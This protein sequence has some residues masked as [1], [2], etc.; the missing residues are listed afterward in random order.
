[1]RDTV[2]EHRA[3]LLELAARPRRRRPVRP[4]GRGHPFRSARDLLRG[5]RRMG[6]AGRP[7]A[8][9]AAGHS[10]GELAALAAGGA[11]DEHDGLR[12]AVERGAIMQRAAEAGGGRDAG[13]DGRAR[14]GPRPGRRIRP[15]D[16]RTTTRPS[17][18]SSPVPQTGSTRPGARRGRPGSARCGSPFAAPS[19]R[20]RWS[21]PWRAFARRF[22]PS[23][24]ARRGCGSS[25]AR[26]LTEFAAPRAEL[27]EALVRPVRWRQTVTALREQGVEHFVETGP[28]QVL[29]KLVER[30]LGAAVASHA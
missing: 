22:A 21:R 24:S 6:A 17:S 19:T 10:L 30:N 26:P 12:L 28:G 27:A 15:D 9:F 14:R 18:S 7:A 1:M 25:R 11:L 20:P 13:A 3:D 4:R 2:A 29:T 5:A 16:R 8:G 23:T